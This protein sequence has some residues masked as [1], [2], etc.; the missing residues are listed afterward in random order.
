LIAIIY[1]YNGVR[2]LVEYFV[3]KDLE[4]ALLSLVLGLGT[5]WLALFLSAARSWSIF[6]K[7]AR[8]YIADYGTTFSVLFFCAVPYFG[9][10]YKLT[11]DYVGY[12]SNATISTLKVPSSFATAS[13]RDW[14]VDLG[15]IPVWAV[16]AAIIPG[17]ILTVLFFFD[18]NVSSLLCQAPEFGLKKGSAYHWDFFVVGV[19]ILLTGLIGIPPVNGLI[20]QAPL[21]T[22]SLCEKRF[23]TDAHGK[24][25]EIVVACHEQRVSGFSQATLIGLTL[26]YVRGIG[27]LPIATLDGLFLYMGIAS[28]GGNTFFQRIVLFITDRDRRDAR[29]LDFLDTVPLKI[30]HRY[31][32][33]QVAILMLIFGVT[34]APY[35]DALFPVCIAI[36]VPLRTYK[37]S[38]WFGAENVD[39]LDSLGKA[40][41]ISDVDVDI[42]TVATVPAQPT[43]QAEDKE[44]VANA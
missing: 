13:G 28:F 27:Y 3:E 26:S 38:K 40:P 23:R 25:V 7:T 14:L 12:E 15:D 20:P 19:Q 21:H 44:E 32:L 33:L 8:V 36:L 24:K 16:F 37:L 11:P 18:H 6:N 35:I 9:D 2:N 34:L 1:I 43:V 41:D 17:F 5:A 29:S 39:A 22:D 42:E 10:N 30:I 31:T 4:P